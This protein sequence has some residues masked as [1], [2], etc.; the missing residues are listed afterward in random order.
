MVPLPYCGAPPSPGELWG[1]FNLDPVLIASLLA[2]ASAYILWIRKEQRR[3]APH[4]VCGWL[5]AGAAFI[6]PLC[7]LSVSLFSA[8]VAQHMI[9]LLVAAPLIALSW[10]LR[11]AQWQ[12]WTAAVTFM[13]A[14]WVWHMPAPYDA[15]F[16]STSLYWG[17]HITLFGSAIVLWS[18]LL[19]HTARNTA[20]ALAVGLSTSMQMGLLGAVLAL[21]GRPLFYAHLI[22]TRV[23]GLTPLQDQQ[24]GGT[25]MWVPGILLFLWVAVRSLR[26]LWSTLEGMSRHESHPTQLS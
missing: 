22:T 20:L 19:H 18:E 24:L 25:L 23:W 12:L 3:R 14:L 10:P 17:M 15:T 16:I 8:R 1:R 26:R 9:L 2:V 4:A 6:S 13:A 21:A 5:I 11:S 7:A